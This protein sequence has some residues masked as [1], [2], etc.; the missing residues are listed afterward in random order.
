MSHRLGWVDLPALCPQQGEQ[1]TSWL[2]GK[3]EGV[4]SESWVALPGPGPVSRCMRLTNWVWDLAR[5][6][7]CRW[8]SAASDPDVNGVAHT[9]KDV[10]RSSFVT[11]GVASLCLAGKQRLFMYQNSITIVVQALAT[12]VLDYCS[13][14]YV[15]LPF[16]VIRKACG[17]K[18]SPVLYITYCL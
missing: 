17:D 15:R 1:W 11:G 3:I 16:T 13:M 7:L 10:P 9:L 5:L 18:L 14:L 6:R 2:Y 8:V 12:S 4:A